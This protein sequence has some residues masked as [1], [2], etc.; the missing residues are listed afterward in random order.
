M[1]TAIYTKAHINI[2][3]ASDANMILHWNSTLLGDWGAYDPTLTVQPVQIIER[4]IEVSL[5]LP[6][7][8]D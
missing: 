3:L 8:N 4:G 1:K 2:I 6:I 5:R 7:C